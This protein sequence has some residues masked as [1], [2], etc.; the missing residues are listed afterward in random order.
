MTTYVTTTYRLEHT[1]QSQPH[2]TGNKSPRAP[3]MT[4]P[5]GTCTPATASPPRLPLLLCMCYK[6]QIKARHRS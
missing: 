2:T 1:Q 5:T 3:P 4:R 6:S